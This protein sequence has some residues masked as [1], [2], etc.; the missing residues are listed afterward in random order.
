MFFVK[1]HRL[2]SGRPFMELFLALS[3]SSANRH[4]AIR[5]LTIRLTVLCDK[6]L[7]NIQAKERIHAKLFDNN[8]TVAL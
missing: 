2:G 5:P 7:Q 6:R 8:T 1:V 3:I 4:R